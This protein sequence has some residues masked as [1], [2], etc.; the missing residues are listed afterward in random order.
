[1]HINIFG[2]R[3]AATTIGFQQDNV[4]LNRAYGPSDLGP[5]LKRHGIDGTV[6]VQAAATLQETE[7][8][9]GLADAT[10]SIKGVVGWIDF[11]RPK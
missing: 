10:P 9:L 11:E 3:C 8:M 2:N 4:M 6:L 1:M 7:Y 5:Y